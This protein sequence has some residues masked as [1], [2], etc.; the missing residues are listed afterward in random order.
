VTKPSDRREDLLFLLS[1]KRPVRRRDRV[2]GIGGYN[3]GPRT[4]EA[5]R[6]ARLTQPWHA[7]CRLAH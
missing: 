6:V 4:I 2:T 1:G 7:A 5:C 3:S